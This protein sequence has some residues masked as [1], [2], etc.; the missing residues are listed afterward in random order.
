[1]CVNVFCIDVQLFT[2]EL[3]INKLN[4]K[5]E[6]TCNAHPTFEMMFCELTTKKVYVFVEADVKNN[7]T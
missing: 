2:A 1:M 6:L 3:S 5:S 7:Q 4:G